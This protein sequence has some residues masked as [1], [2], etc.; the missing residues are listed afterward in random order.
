[1]KRLHPTC[2]TAPVPKGSSLLWGPGVFLNGAVSRTEE[3]EHTTG[4]QIPVVCWLD[5][6]ASAL[7]FGA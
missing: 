3:G 6:Y 5:L 2:M 7:G 1:M 4:T